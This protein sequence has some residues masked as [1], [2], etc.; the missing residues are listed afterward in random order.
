MLAM[1]PRLLAILHVYISNVTVTS[2][3]SYTNLLYKLYIVNTFIK[4]RIGLILNK[5][6][7]KCIYSFIHMLLILLLV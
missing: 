2:D 1:Y 6:E 5:H 4:I 7:T 3:D